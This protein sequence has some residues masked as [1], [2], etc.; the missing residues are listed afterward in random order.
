MTAV[1]AS[2]VCQC[3]P[4]AL[5][6]ALFSSYTTYCIYVILQ[7]VPKPSSKCN[8][9]IHVLV[10]YCTC[11]TSMFPPP[12]LLLQ[13]SSYAKKK[14]IH[15]TSYDSRKRSNAAYLIGCYMVRAGDEAV[16]LV[17]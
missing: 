1:E 6:N 13:S 9:I 12:S 11:V 5:K 3:F 16:V 15:Y 4:A 8:I 10:M 17:E 7:C 2:V 14:I